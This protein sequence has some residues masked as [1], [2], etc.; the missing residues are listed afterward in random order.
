MC[1]QLME[2]VNVEIHRSH[3]LLKVAVLLWFVNDG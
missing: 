2:E 3:E 1:E